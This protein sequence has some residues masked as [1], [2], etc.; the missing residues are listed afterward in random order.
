MINFLLTKISVPS[1]ISLRKIKEFFGE[2]YLSVKERQNGNKQFSFYLFNEILQFPLFCAEKIFKAISNINTITKNQFCDGLIS[3]FFG[4]E[5][6]IICLLF[7]ILD[8]DTD[9]I[10]NIHD[11]K[12]FFIYLHSMKQDYKTEKILYTIIDNFFDNCVELDFNKFKSKCKINYDLILL[13]KFLVH[14][15]RFFSF[16]QIQFFQERILL[17]R[18]IIINEK[19]EKQN[20]DKNKISNKLLNYISLNFTEEEKNKLKE[21]IKEKKIIE[22]DDDEIFKDL[23]N[24]E[25][26][27]EITMDILDKEKIINHH[28][29]NVTRENKKEKNSSS[30]SSNSINDDFKKVNTIIKH[31]QFHKKLK[32]FFSNIKMEDIDDNHKRSFTFHTAKFTVKNLIKHSFILN[33]N[34]EFEFLSNDHI[35]KIRL[36]IIKNIIFVF[37]LKEGFE[38]FSYS[39]LI[40]LNSTFLEI[41]KNLSFN[42]KI[43]HSINL[44]ST[45]QN[46]RHSIEFFTD[47]FE[48]LNKF[49]DIF[50]KENVY[51]DINKEYLI[52]N[53]EIGKGKF[54]L[55]QICTKINKDTKKNFCVKV[56]NKFKNGIN[57]EDYKIMMWEKSIFLFLKKF[58]NKNIVKSYDLFEDSQNLYL[59]HEYIKGFDLKEYQSKIKENNEEINPKMLINLSSQI[60][61]SINYLHSYGIIHR[62]I[63]HTNILINEK[64]IIKIIDFGLSRVLGK[65]EYTMNPYGSLCFKAPEIVL[66]RPYNYKVDIW[67]L[68]ITLYFL[69]YGHTPF[70]K[71]NSNIL[72][73]QI[74]NETIKFENDFK[75]ELMAN[76]INECL[77]KNFDLRPTSDD[78]IKKY[79]SNIQK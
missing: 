31:N 16:E 36:I 27:I 46:Y 28:S 71:V 56:I 39:N 69:L 43:I 1:G 54:G 15:N 67:S 23:E 17:N 51:K 30:S 3:L 34:N 70:N 18:A 45:Y 24:F 53:N 13:I 61:N 55:C 6:D 66:E 35:T 64:N 65:N 22:E 76:I 77:T 14:L 29:E 49:K 57:E 5:N 4:K 33:N 75:F 12:L 47:S 58:P 2:I 41:K 63:K 48:I 44:I 74:C 40:F 68:G 8:F 32:K 37:K 78:I 59:I 72:K 62:D 11:T 7:S 20:I 42:V 26:D 79:F 38:N 25:K 60:L 10:I 73:D 9:N 52:T 19:E 50:Y 21:E